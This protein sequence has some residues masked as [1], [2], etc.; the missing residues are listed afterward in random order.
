MTSS[1]QRRKILVVDDNHDAAD[2]LAMLL[3]FLGYETR[4]P[5]TGSRGWT[6]P[7]RSSPTW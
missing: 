4:P 3:D 6:P 2:T 5:T 7:R 1:A